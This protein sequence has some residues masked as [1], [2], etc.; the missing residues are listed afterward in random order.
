MV[1]GVRSPWYYLKPLIEGCY[2]GVESIITRVD[3]EIIHDLSCNSVTETLKTCEPLS[4]HLREDARDE[5]IK[6]LKVSDGWKASNIITS[7]ATPESAPWCIAALKAAA[8]IISSK[9][10]SDV[11]RGAC[12]N[13]IGY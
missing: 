7:G 9:K 2:E 11:V 1:W 13:L 8:V 3:D 5:L 12:M 4:K 6:A 10:C